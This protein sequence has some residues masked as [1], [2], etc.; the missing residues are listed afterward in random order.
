MKLINTCQGKVLM[1]DK[2]LFRIK[3]D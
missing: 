2:L 1:L 3:S